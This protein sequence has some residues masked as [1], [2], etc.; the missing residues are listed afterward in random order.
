MQRAALIAGIAVVM[1]MVTI[2][3]VTVIDYSGL[4][5]VLGNRNLA[6]IRVIEMNGSEQ[7][8]PHNLCQDIKPQNVR[9][10]LPYGA[11]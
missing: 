9:D 7:G 8:D 6:V 1:L 5:N 3:L 4:C 11:G 10:P 2:A